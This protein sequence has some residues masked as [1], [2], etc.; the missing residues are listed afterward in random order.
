MA[1][2][3]G[4]RRINCVVTGRPGRRLPFGLTV[5][6]DGRQGADAVEALNLPRM[7]PV[8]FD[9]YA[10]FA[11]PL[12]DFI[13]EMKNRGFADRIIEMERGQSVSI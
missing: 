9:D 5:T 3:Q 4:N 12:C 7:I 11:S 2:A 1:G 10:V 8:H 6:M 13:D